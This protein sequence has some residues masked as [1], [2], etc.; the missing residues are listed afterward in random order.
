MA[1]LLLPVFED[2]QACVQVTGIVVL[3]IPYSV[4]SFFGLRKG[5]FCQQVLTWR[6]PE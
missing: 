6:N 5:C 3:F 2:I 4:C 1:G